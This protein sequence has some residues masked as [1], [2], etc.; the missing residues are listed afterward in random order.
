MSTVELLKIEHGQ[1]TGALAEPVVGRWMVETT[2]PDLDRRERH[3]RNCLPKLTEVAREHGYAIGVHGSLRRDLDIIAV[4]WIVEFSK[5][6]LLAKALQIAAS[7]S[8]GSWKINFKPH[9]RVCYSL[10]IGTGAY[11]DLSVMVV[12]PLFF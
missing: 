7:G 8:W 2:P 11:I 12:P 3:Y 6:E 5:A 4:P 1:V 10:F 9:G